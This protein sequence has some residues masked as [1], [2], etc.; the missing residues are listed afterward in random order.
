[1]ANI[2][3]QWFVEGDIRE[4]HL[5]LLQQ[6][7]QSPHGKIW[8]DVQGDDIPAD[9]VKGFGLHELS[10]SDAKR[11]R[12]PPKVEA[13]DDYTY[14]LQRG[15]ETLS[16]ELEFS[17]VQ[18]SLFLGERFLLTFHQKPSYSINHWWSD[19]ERQRWVQLDFSYLSARILNT[20]ASRYLET[21]LEFE[22]LLTELEDQVY[23]DTTDNTLNALNRY[24]SR[25]RKLRRVF[26]YHEKTSK[27]L[28]EL[29]GD[30]PG[31]VLYHWQDVYDKNERLCTLC[32]MYY[33]LTG[34]LVDGFLSMASHRLNKTM[35]I[36]TVITAIFVPLGFL[37][38]LYGMNFDYIP[39]L[40]FQYGYFWLLG[41]MGVIA[42][43]LISL[44]KLKK[45]L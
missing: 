40:K 8:V 20:L 34:D 38:G 3:V 26:Y 32:D 28:L 35:Q 39:E 25:L 16:T 22:G 11:L 23:S 14:I 29:H 27:S 37:A 4:G 13:F 41:S 2:R 12:H 44:F 1:M 19:P 30:W 42:V 24:R 7:W 18:I 43:S 33:E 17:H 10:V 45:W 36:L 31:D 6:Y 5:D 21:L 9:I 15:I